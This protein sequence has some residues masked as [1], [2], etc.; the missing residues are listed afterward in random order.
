MAAIAADPQRPYYESWIE[1]LESL[2][3]DMNLAT[4]EALEAA[5]PTER[6]P[7]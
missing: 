4:P 3:I 1:A 2:V 5:T 7:L 6:A